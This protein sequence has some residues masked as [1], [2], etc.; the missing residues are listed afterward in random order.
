MLTTRNKNTFN[1]CRHTSS[2]KY[3]VIVWVLQIYGRKLDATQVHIIYKLI[4]VELIQTLTH[5][6][7]EYNYRWPSRH[8]IH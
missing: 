3:Q 7:I 5:P 6:V 8:L 1:L 2:V 4:Q